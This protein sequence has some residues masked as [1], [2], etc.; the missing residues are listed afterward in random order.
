MGNI[1]FSN[2]SFLFDMKKCTKCGEIKELDQFCKNNA[3]KDGVN[4]SCKSCRKLLNKN[5]THIIK[6]YNKRYKQQIPNPNKNYKQLPPD[7]N[8]I[9]YI[10]N[11]EKIKK[12]IKANWVYKYNN[13][14]LF[15]LSNDIRVSINRNIK[16]LNFTKSKRTEEILGCT[17]EEFKLYLE[18]KFEPWMTW[19]NKGYPKDGVFEF[20]KNW[21]VDHILPISSATTEGEIIKL[22]H[23]SNFQPLCSK[24]NREI[25]R[26]LL[27][28]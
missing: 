8:K 2:V 6:E 5:N 3:N 22:N 17:F 20:N 15:K 12:Q 18:S 19:E 4:N 16:S 1:V 24:V 28:Y 21:D 23:F 25:K 10:N 14:P 26:N 11:K 27:D 9:Y 7:Y 13:D